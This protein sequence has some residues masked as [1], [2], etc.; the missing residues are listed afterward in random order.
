MYAAAGDNLF[1]SAN[2]GLNWSAPSKL[3]AMPHALAVVPQHRYTLLA[4]TGS[5]IY[6]STSDGSLWMPAEG[7]SGSANIFALDPIS[8]D[9]I[10]A[11]LNAQVV[12]STDGGV[13]WSP[14]GTGSDDSEFAT[15]LAT[16]RQ[17]PGVVYAGT[18]RGLYVSSDSDPSEATGVGIVNLDATDAELAFTAYGVDGTPISGSGITNP[19]TRT[20][21]AGAQVSI[22]DVELWGEGLA[23]AQPVGWFEVE[24]S[25]RI[26]GFFLTFNRS[27]STIDGAGA[28]SKTLRSWLFTEITPGGSTQIHVANPNLETA[29]VR[30]ELVDP[31]GITRGECARSIPPKGAL[32]EPLTSLFPELVC[33]PSDYLRVRS[34]QPVV[35]YENMGKV[36][37]FIAGLDGQ[38]SS[39]GA[40]SLFC[41][42]YVTGGQDW[43]TTLTIVNPSDQEATAE[44]R[45]IGDD[46]AQVGSARTVTIPGKGKTYIDDPKFFVAAG[47]VQVQGYV[48]I[49]SSGPAGAPLIG[50]ATFGDPA[51]RT[52]G[53]ALPLVQTLTSDLVFSQVASN[54]TWWTGVTIVNP[55]DNAATLKMQLFDKTGSAIR[56]RTLVIPPGQRISKL[57]TEQ[58]YFKDILGLDIN[59]GYIRVSGDQGVAAFAAFGTHRMSAVAAVPAQVVR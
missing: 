3:F 5:G 41:P 7:G 28:F 38:D 44:L 47:S 55:G 56:S 19:A 8:P 32:A 14:M 22:L 27:L 49:R 46:G 4:A 50:S 40:A 58:E 37:Q 35:P 1:K 26:D 34:D 29:N 6:R 53:S 23:A 43:S 12:R 9:D 13:T 21:K 31:G 59:S 51:R 18:D 33:S 16:H 36:S 11:V 42:Q 10:Y 45:F 30:F 24:S 17:N 2:G 39:G 48:A 54:A 25:A 20:L 15:V 57:L 52:L